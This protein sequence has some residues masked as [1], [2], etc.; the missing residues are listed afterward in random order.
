M[1]TVDITVHV[2]DMQIMKTVSSWV[3][4]AQNKK[5]LKKYEVEVV[6]QEGLNKLGDQAN[7][8]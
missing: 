1:D 4:V 6:T 8:Y 5:S 3:S 2:P 7:F